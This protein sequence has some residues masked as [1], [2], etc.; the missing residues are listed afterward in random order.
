MSEMTAK[1]KKAYEKWLKLCQKIREHDAPVPQETEREKRE[2]IEYLNKPG[3][4]AEYDK[5]YFGRYIDSDFAWFHHEINDAYDF[6]DDIFLVPELPREHA[7]SVF[8]IVFRQIR[9]HTQKRLD[10]LLVGGRTDPKAKKLIG[11]I[12]AEL[13]NNQRL[14]ADY[15][16]FNIMGTHRE[17]HFSIGG[18]IGVWA[19]SPEQEPAGVREAAKRP[20][21]GVCDDMDSL[22]KY[23]KKPDRVETDMN[24]IMG[25]F[26]NCLSLKNKFFAF[27]NNRVCEDGLTANIVGDVKEGDP[28][29]EGIIHIKA[30]A[31]EDP[32][33]RKK[34]LIAEGG[35]PAWN[36]YTIEMLEKRFKQIGPSNTSRQFYHTHKRIG[37]FFIEENLPWVTALPWVSYDGLIQYLDPAY[38]SSGKSCYRALI[39]LGKIGLEYDILYAWMRTKGDFPEAQRALEKEVKNRIGIPQELITKNARFTTSRFQNWVEAGS[40]Q[41]AR[42]DNIYKLADHERGFSWRPRYDNDQLGDKLSNIESLDQFVDKKLIRFSSEYQKNEDMIT[43]RNQF[44]DFPNDFYDGP[45]CVYRAKNKLDKITQRSQ[46][47]SRTGSFAKNTDRSLH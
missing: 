41:K 14:I 13:R 30:Y 40:L 45:D 8:V 18:D 37:K 34:L 44:I 15:G 25:E 12:E 20:N 26:M 35:V 9:L 46:S 11:D 24:W 2:R 29:R 32:K 7:K 28:K 1:E 16:D 36:R 17:G 3:N 6:N 31:T 23:H 21:S 38:G 43:L 19:F 42:L 39:L 5:Y 33:T 27:C 22:K 10:G 47:E 4:A